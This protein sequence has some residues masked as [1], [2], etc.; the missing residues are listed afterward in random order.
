LD[1]Q[2]P[3]REGSAKQLGFSATLFSALCG[4]KPKLERYRIGTVNDI[5]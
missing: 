2:K 1:L 3:E 4:E 5:I